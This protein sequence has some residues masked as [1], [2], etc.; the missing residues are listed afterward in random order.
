MAPGETWRIHGRPDAVY[1]S[2]GL[3]PSKN[4]RRP[5]CSSSRCPS[6][7]VRMEAMTKMARPAVA[8]Q[9]GGADLP[10]RAPCGRRPGLPPPADRDREEAVDLRQDTR[11]PVVP[12]DEDS[13]RLGEQEQ[14]DCSL[15][16]SGVAH[17]LGDQDKST[18][19]RT[20]VTRSGVPGPKV[21]DIARKE[22]ERR[23]SDAESY[24]T[25]SRLAGRRCRRSRYLGIF[26]LH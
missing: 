11:L 13:A 12:S 6:P 8:R 5:S 15:R 1:G 22:S 18:R 23:L 26:C 19:A 14:V 7:D 17:Q 2:S 20:S 9:R 4:S 24:R 21:I 16:S 10:A 3:G 25:R